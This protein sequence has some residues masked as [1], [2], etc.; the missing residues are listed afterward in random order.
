VKARSQK[1]NTFDI[2]DELEDN[3][4]EIRIHISR[5]D[6]KQNGQKTKDKKRSTQ[7]VT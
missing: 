7:N 6:G 1:L 5:K 2:K 3:K 4:E